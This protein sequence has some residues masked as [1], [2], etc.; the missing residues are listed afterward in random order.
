MYMCVHI[1]G[2]THCVDMYGCMFMCKGM[3]T[4]VGHLDISVTS[5]HFSFVIYSWKDKIKIFFNF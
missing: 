3:S 1:Y 5:R 2:F 4:G